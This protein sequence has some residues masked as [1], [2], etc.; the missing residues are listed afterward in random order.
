MVDE[1]DLDGLAVEPLRVKLGGDIYTIDVTVDM[2]MK[3][4]AARSRA[5]AAG[6]DGNQ[7]ELMVT[8]MAAAGMP[9]ETY[10]KL[11]AAQAMKLTEIVTE[12]FFPGAAAAVVETPDDSPSAGGSPSPPSSGTSE[13]D[14]H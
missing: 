12:R 1:I 2:M 10:L 11:G 4:D 14:I 5:G 9:R 3:F 6:N 7:M 13:P 8:I